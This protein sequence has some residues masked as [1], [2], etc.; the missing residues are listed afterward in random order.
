MVWQ[1]LVNLKLWT[2]SKKISLKDVWQLFL[3]GGL[4]CFLLLLQTTCWSLWVRQ[5]KHICSNMSYTRKQRC[6]YPVWVFYS[7]VVVSI[8]TSI[9]LF[10]HRK[11]LNSCSCVLDPLKCQT[12]HH[13]GFFHH[14]QWPNLPQSSSFFCLSRSP[15]ISGTGYGVPWQPHRLQ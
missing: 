10:W 13:Q 15:S 4:I 5:K 12:A 7:T 11:I 3:F 8:S 14:Q 6:T 2:K 1:F 9:V